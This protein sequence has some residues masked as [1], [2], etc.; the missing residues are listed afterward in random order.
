MLTHRYFH[1]VNLGFVGYFLLQISAVET[2]LFNA[3]CFDVFFNVPPKESSF[4]DMWKVYEFFV[5]LNS[6]PANR[7]DFS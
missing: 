3:A 2:I 7:L 4:I 6:S 1:W 5:S